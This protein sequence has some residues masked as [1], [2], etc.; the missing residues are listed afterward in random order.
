MIKALI[1]NTT[2]TDFIYKKRVIPS[3]YTGIVTME[4]DELIERCSNREIRVAYYFG[5]KENL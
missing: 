2:E 3:L 1:Q 4:L 5:G